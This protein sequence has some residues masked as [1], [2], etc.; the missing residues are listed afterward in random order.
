MKAKQDNREIIN[1]VVDIYYNAGKGFNK[2]KRFLRKKFGIV[3]SENELERRL[4]NLKIKRF[5]ELNKIED[6]TRDS[7]TN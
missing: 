2:A 7:N 5:D 4:K 3:I 6:D 1:Y